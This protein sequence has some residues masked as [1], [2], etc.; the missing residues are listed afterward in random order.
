MP[1]SENGGQSIISYEIFRKLSDQPES[2]WALATSNGGG[3]ITDI[4]AL[5]YT[6]TG[7]SATA[8]IVSDV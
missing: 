8:V 6:D 1:P 3:I 4:N 5:A 7:L 2:A